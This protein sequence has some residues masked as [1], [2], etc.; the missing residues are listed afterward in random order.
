V[1]GAASPPTEGCTCACARRIPDRSVDSTGKVDALISQSGKQFL[2]GRQASLMFRHITT[3]LRI[4]FLFLVQSVHGRWLADSSLALI[5]QRFTP[6][7]S[8]AGVRRSDEHRTGLVPGRAPACTA[9][10]NSRL[11]G[12][13]FYFT[14]RSVVRRLV[15]QIGPGLFLTGRKAAASARAPA[16]CA[17]APF[18]SARSFLRFSY[19]AASF[20]L[21]GR[22]HP[23]SQR[24][25]F[26]ASSCSGIAR[27]SRQ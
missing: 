21:D 2:A 14:R 3:R 10:S 5:Y 18:S 1:R 11:N 17:A 20:R 8:G 26:Q 22:Q 24:P 19:Q 16:P 27:Y 13:L 7:A 4:C 23:C 6:F 12:H 9:F 15:P 25:L